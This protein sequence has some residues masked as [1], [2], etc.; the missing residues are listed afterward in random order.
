MSEN[1]DTYGDEPKDNNKTPVKPDVAKL[2]DWKNPPSFQDLYQNYTDAQSDHVLVIEKFEER[3]INMDGGSPINAPKGKSRA[4]PRVI[5]K[6]AEWKYPALEEPFLNSENMFEVKPRTFEDVES[7]KQNQTLI[8]YQWNVQI[9]KT[10]LIGNTVRTIYDDG[11]VIAKVGWESDEDIVMV[12]KEVPV[13]ASAEESIMII[14]QAIA[15]GSMSQEQAQQIISSGQPIPIGSEVIQVEKTVLVKNQPSYEVCD[16]RN[17]VLDPTA[18][19]KVEDLQF[20]IHEYDTTMSELKTEEYKEETETNPET[21]E[22]EVFEYG[23]YHNLDKVPIENTND[24]REYYNDVDEYES[25]FE[26]QDKP[27]KKLRAYEYWGYWD[28]NGDGETEVIVATWIGKQL[29]RMELSPFPFNGFPFAIAKYLP[30]VNEMYGQSDGDLLVENQ[31][32]IGRMKRAAYDITA[33]VAVGQEFI[34]EQFF[35]SPSQKDNYRSG[36]TVYFRHGMDPRNSVF[37]SKIESV[38]NAVFDMIALENTDA[39]SLTGT[40]SFSQ[41]L[42]SQAFGSV[43]TGIRSSLDATSKRELSILRRLANQFFKELGAKTIQMNQVFIDEKTVIRLTNKEFVSINRN[44]I[45]GEF[46]LKLAISTPEKDN[47]KA[48]KLNTM[49]QTNAASMDP[50]LA[51]IIYAEMARLWNLPGIEEKILTFEPKPDPAAEQLKQMQL[52]NAGLENKKLQMEIANMAKN[53]DSEN[54]KITERNSRTAQN[55]NTESEENLATARWRNAQA[56]KLEQDSDLARLKFARIQDGTD[57]KENIE[58]QEMS[59]ISKMDYLETQQNR[60]R[61]ANDERTVDMFDQAIIDEDSDRRNAK[62]DTGSEII[63]DKATQDPEL[64]VIVPDY[65]ESTGSLI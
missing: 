55:L 9:D 25:S 53:I 13:Y 58:D 63:E 2:N 19:G 62:L 45:A 23:I 5:R 61:E 16:T 20:L 7:A 49:M 17:V 3:K 38:P 14:E 44:E 12:D 27:R 54:S 43:A 37:K 33:D 47:E 15:S 39:E 32:A 52:E 40:K 57:R 24:G 6:Q 56:E 4:R 64:T 18:N 8:N 59:H 28:T 10:E 46:D 22:E 31:E 65:T 42:G 1:L 51:K 21:G 36:K 26:F 11:T 50:S 60:E 35:A 34:D 29:I 41:G 48:E 30:R